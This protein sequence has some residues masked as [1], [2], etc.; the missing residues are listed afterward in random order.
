MVRTAVL[1]AASQQ[2]GQRYAPVGISNRHIHLS[3][4][5]LEILFGRG[6]ALKPKS[7]LSQPGQFAAEETVALAGPK[8]KL[9]KVRVLGPVRPETQVEISITD[10]FALGVKPEVRMSGDLKGTPGIRVI[11]PAG[12]VDLLSGVMVAARHLH[13]SP[14]E[15]Q[16]YGLKNGDSVSLRSTGGRGIVFENVIVRSGDGHEL[17]VHLDVDEANAAQLKNG[18]LLEVCS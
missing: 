17:E 6:Y 3:Q 1:Q 5:D 2:S 14:G 15:A 18:D 8:G 9:E 16:A 12:S 10:S 7:S 13:M 4:S 11:G